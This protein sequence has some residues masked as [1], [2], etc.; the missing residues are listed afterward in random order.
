[1]AA[2]RE[3]RSHCSGHSIFVPSSVLRVSFFARLIE[4]IRCGHF[5]GA[6]R[7]SSS[8]WWFEVAR[9]FIYKTKKVRSL[10]INLCLQSLTDCVQPCERLMSGALIEPRV[11]FGCARRGSLKV[12]LKKGRERERE[13]SSLCA[14]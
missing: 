9:K 8:V 13:K 2:L 6:F 4:V 11:V 3:A 12:Y 5:G 14:I 7:W 1:M 10:L